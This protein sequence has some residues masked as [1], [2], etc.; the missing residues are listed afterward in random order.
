MRS[1]KT[2]EAARN[3]TVDADHAYSLATVKIE[4]YTAYLRTQFQGSH[5]NRITGEDVLMPH[6]WRARSDELPSG[7]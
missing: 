7:S 5:Y 3:L 1:W 2:A 4:F 6:V